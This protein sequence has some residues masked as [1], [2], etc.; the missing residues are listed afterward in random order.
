[1]SILLIFLESTTELYMNYVNYVYAD[2]K[3]ENVHE[4]WNRKRVKIYIFL[5]FLNHS[6][7]RFCFLRPSALGVNTLISQKPTT[8]GI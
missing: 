7:H 2:N 1:M 4:V 3:I 8:V 5:V 6:E